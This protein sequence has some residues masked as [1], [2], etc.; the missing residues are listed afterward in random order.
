MGTIA[1]SFGAVALGVLALGFVAR[2]GDAHHHGDTL[3]ASAMLFMTWA[4]SNVLTAL[5]KPPDSWL[6]YPVMDLIC[7]CAV[8]WMWFSKR[9]A[10]KFIL[11]GLF[12]LE[13]IIH[14]AFWLHR[15]QTPWLQYNYVLSL[16]V[17]F[18]VQLLTTAWPGGAYVAARTL[19]LYRSP[20]RLDPRSPTSG[21]LG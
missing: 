14:V 12:L 1:L 15:V 7:G 18:A 5:Y 4:I 8:G 17:V 9:A 20:R 21:R 11:A 6:L 19:G 2:R 10:W 3:A 13:C 16:N